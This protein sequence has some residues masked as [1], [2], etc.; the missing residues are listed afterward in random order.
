MLTASGLKTGRRQAKVNY[1]QLGRLTRLH[2]VIPAVFKRESR[3]ALGW[4]PANTTVSQ[5]HFSVSFR[6]LRGILETSA[7]T[8]IPRK[9]RN[10]RM[11]LGMI[12][13]RLFL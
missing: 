12:V 13:E 10:D 7:T 5:D 11:G 3:G 4:I 8:K 1:E 2:T 9:T 6:V